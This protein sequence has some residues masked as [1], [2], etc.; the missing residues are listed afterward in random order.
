MGHWK[1]SIAPHTRVLNDREA[2]SVSTGRSSGGP[3]SNPRE[4][5][6]WNDMVWDGFGWISEDAWR[7]QQGRG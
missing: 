1:T 5:Q 4:G 7:A 6:R 3:P 2:R